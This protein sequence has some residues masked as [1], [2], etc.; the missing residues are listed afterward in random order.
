MQGNVTEWCLDVYT[1]DIS[2]LHGA[3]STAGT[4]QSVCR[5]GGWDQGLGHTASETRDF[6]NP[7]S[8]TKRR[9]VRVFC[10]AGLE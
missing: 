8:A 9:G 6:S 2:T 5:G 7:A 3:I 4:G 10:R 1:N